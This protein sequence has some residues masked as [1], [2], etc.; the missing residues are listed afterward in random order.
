M[1]AGAALIAATYGLVRL[2]FGLHLPAMSADLAIDSA[3]AGLISAAGSIV[4]GAAAVIGFFASTRHPRALVVAAI[5]TAGGGAI[6]IAF[7]AHAGILAAAC[8]LSSAGAG[9]ASPALVR[10]VQRGVRSGAVDRAQAAVNAGTGPGLAIAALIAAAT[11]EQWRA[12]WMI[13]AGAT[14]LSAAS[15]LVLDRRSRPEQGEPRTRDAASS[16]AARLPPA[17]WWS[18]HLHAAAAAAL[19]GIGAAAVWTYG[20]SLMTEAATGGDHSL[21]GWIALGC[22]GAAVILTGRPTAP[23]APPRLWLLTTLVAAAATALLGVAAIHPV[24]ALAACALFGWGY[25]AATGALIAWTA[26]IAPDHAAAGTAL[27]FV[28][29]MAG[30]AAGAA[31]LGAALPAVGPAATF[32]IAAAA[33]AASGLLAVTVPA[34]RARPAARAV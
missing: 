20:R 13:A 17:P 33:A 31:L 6:G 22:G 12:A 16:T 1:A 28:V 32:G 2:A 18:A 4:Y 29:F 3:A 8:A 15:V 21:L 5:V 34:R 23:L 30:Q 11:A 7:A 25:V 27:L 19:F 14:A 26:R 9:L 10:I 24:A